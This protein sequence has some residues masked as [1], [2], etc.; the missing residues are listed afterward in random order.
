MVRLGPCAWFTVWQCWEVRQQYNEKTLGLFKTKWCGDGMVALCS[1]TFYCQD[2][3]VW[4]WLSSK[5]LQKVTH[6]DALTNEVYHNILTTWLMVLS[7][8][9]LGLAWVDTCTP[10][11]SSRAPCPTCNQKGIWQTKTSTMPTCLPTF[12]PS[13][14]HQCWQPPWTTAIPTIGDE[15]EVHDLQLQWHFRMLLTSCSHSGKSTLTT[16]LMAW[17]SHIITWMSAY[18]LVFYSHMQL[19]YREQ[20]H[21]APCPIW[22]IIYSE[23]GCKG[24]SNELIHNRRQQ[25]FRNIHLWIFR[26]QQSTW[27]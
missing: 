20:A 2:S 12:P 14:L 5:D 13:C 6:A 8:A 26:M 16:Q 4:D 1:K 11:G 15:Y 24:C 18:I 19:A 7:T 17:S 10:S 21:Q 23:T 3:E 9:E 27:H 25:H 22:M